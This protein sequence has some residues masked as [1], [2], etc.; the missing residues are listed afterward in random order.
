M[1]QGDWDRLV[2]GKAGSA[3]TVEEAYNRIVFQQFNLHLVDRQRLAEAKI[4]WSYNEG[5]DE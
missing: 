2:A 1:C 3:L 4:K 5:F